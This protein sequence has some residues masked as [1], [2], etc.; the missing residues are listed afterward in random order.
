MGGKS[1]GKS[2]DKVDTKWCQIL[3]G[4]NTTSYEI[5]VNHTDNG[6]PK[7]K[8]RWKASADSAPLASAA[9][10]IQAGPALILSS[11]HIAWVFVWVFKNDSIPA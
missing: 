8:P 11:V 5:C 2:R 1:A 7:E 6:N 9:V 10:D 4:T 3:V